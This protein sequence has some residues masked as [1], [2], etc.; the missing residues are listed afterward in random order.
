M[1][2]NGSNRMNG[3]KRG[4]C[5]VCRIPFRIATPSLILHPSSFRPHPSSSVLTRSKISA[6]LSSTPTGRIT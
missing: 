6:W 5:Q 4:D 3:A 1:R 2:D